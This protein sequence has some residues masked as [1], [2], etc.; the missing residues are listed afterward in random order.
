MT[1]LFIDLETFSETPI[2]HGTYRYAANA[3]IMLFAWAIDDAPAQ[4][5]DATSGEPMPFDLEVTLGV[6]DEVWAHNSMFD[7]TV[8]RYAMPDM[9]PPIERW[10]DTMVQAL[11]HSLPGKLETLCQV[12]GVP[13]DLAK[14]KRGKQLVQLFCKPRPKTSKVA[15]ATRETHPTEWA[16]FVDYARLDVEAMR[17][18]NKR[19]PTWNYRGDELALWHLDQT[20]NDR[21][22]AIDL[23]LANAALAAV[24]AEQVV[25]AARTVEMTN[26]EV[27]TATQRDAMLQHMLAEYGV[28][29]PDLQASTLERRLDDPDI[30][31]P[32]KDLLRVRL[33]AST[34]STSKYKALVR[35]TNLDGRIRGLLQ[36]AGASRTARWAGRTF[37]P[38]NLP[39]PVLK[40][41]AVDAGIA[42]MKAGAAGLIYAN[43]ME[44]ASSAIRGCIVAPPGKK[45]VI[46][47]LSNIEGRALAWLAGEE[48]KLQAFR[49]FDAGTGHDLYKLA[50]AK[51]FGIAPE[52][53][54]KDMR[55][56]GKVQELAC[57]GADTPVLTH[58]GVKRLDQITTEDLLWDGEQWVQHQG[59]LARGQRQTLNLSGVAVTPDHLIKTGPTWTPA[60][61]LASC[62]N[63][64]TRALET[65]SENL[66]YSVW[67]ADYRVPAASQ[68]LKCSAHAAQSPILSLRTTYAKE[69]AHGATLALKKLLGT[70]VKTFGLTPTFALTTPTA[71]GCST[72]YPLPTPGATAPRRNSTRPTEGGGSWFTR[73]GVKTGALFSRTF[74]LLT[75]G[76][77]PPTT[78]TAWMS[79]GATNLAICVLSLWARTVEAIS[80]RCGQC[81]RESSSLR[82]VFDILNSGPNNR[83]TILT[84]DGPLIAHNCGYAGGV[85]AFSTFA[86]AY[87][88]DL[89]DLARSVLPS[90]PTDLVDEA[91]RFLEWM[92]KQPKGS[93]F[94][95]SDDA[96]VGCDVVKRGWRNGHPAIAAWWP[97]LEQAFRDAIDSPGY[98]FDCG[99][100]K[101]RRDGNWLRILLPSG[102]YLCYPAPEIDEQGRCSYM[103]VD[104]YTRKWQRIHTYSGK[105]AENCI[106]QGTE[107][108]TSEGWTAIESVAPYSRVWDGEAWVPHAGVAAKGW[109]PVMRAFG[110]DMT[111]DHLILTTEGWKNASQSEGHNRAACRLPDGL[112]LPRERREAFAVGGAMRL[113]RREIDGPQ[114]IQEA[115]RAG[116][117][118][119]VRVQAARDHWRAQDNARHDQAPGLRG[120]AQHVGAL[121]ESTAQSVAALRRAGHRGLRQVAGVFR[122]LLG[123]HGAN[124]PEWAIA[125][126]REKQRGVH[127]VELPLGY[128]QGAGQQHTGERGGRGD[129]GGAA[130]RAT[131][132]ETLDD[133]LPAFSGSA[134]GE[135]GRGPRRFA[136]VFDL[137]NC[138]PRNRF[139][140]RGADG[141]PLIVHN[142]TQAFARDVLA[143][144]MPAIEAEGYRIVLSVHDELLTE[145]PDTPEFNS[146]HLAA[147]MSTVPPWAEGLPLAAAGFETYRYRK[148]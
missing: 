38:Q 130:G 107:V 41:A 14:A 65:G 143:H 86:T 25:L 121:L 145:T 67:S 34:S 33:Q 115:G 16:E 5:W 71:G 10:R 7:R 22:V 50:Y 110:V 63:T 36:F 47:D 103:G 43:V 140:V 99:T 46:A 90:A 146:D 72:A 137:V 82:P 144:N 73:P 132:G 113:R 138:G 56:V 117:T 40:D 104:Q 94:G 18:C 12:L 55:Q 31:E 53:V 85:G 24:D 29:L 6:A 139:V 21:G 77:Y 37:Q 102:R 52:A 48:W 44:V 60:G 11:C 111:P 15:R 96:F 109:K 124:V 27:Q 59:L 120:V 39:R 129:H 1:R 2:N 58:T 106:A 133:V 30:P 28:H 70:G 20:I 19:L 66:P 116:D 126:P 136:Q 93:T 88:L 80:A 75:G 135:A 119:V 68:W 83:F 61:Q 32:M 122:E 91:R 74:S 105:L 131:W 128:R 84:A 123:R 42:A 148:D 35:A 17:E 134:R 9:C 81:S 57:F 114:R 54:T 100:V 89:D 79:T 45:L 101:V 97:V 112:A 62:A 8:M 141:R 69:R 95:L 78:L 64:L 108:L 125:G 92:R 76:T 3:E 4:V 147:L 49:E 118:S 142:C 51:S 23:D 98:T 127:T 13:D 26:G 87:G